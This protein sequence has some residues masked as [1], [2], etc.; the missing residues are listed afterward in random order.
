MDQAAVFQPSGQ[1]L[2]VTILVLPDASLMS[3]AATLDPMRAAN[4]ISGQPHYS[5]KV[6]SMDGRSITTSCGLS[7]QADGMAPSRMT[8]GSAFLRLS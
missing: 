6:V 8:T 5:W 3:M 1:P 2:A 4:R 7:L